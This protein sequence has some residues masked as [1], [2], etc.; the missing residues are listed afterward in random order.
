MDLASPIIHEQQCFCPAPHSTWACDPDNTDPFKC[1]SGG[2]QCVCSPGDLASP[3]NLSRQPSNMDLASASNFLRQRGN[4]ASTA[5][6]PDWAT[7]KGTYSFVKSE[8]GR[9]TQTSGTKP[10]RAPYGLAGD[11]NHPGDAEMNTAC[12]WISACKGNDECMKRCPVA[13][14]IGAKEG[15][16]FPGAYAWDGN[17]RGLWQVN[18]ATAQLPGDCAYHP[19]EGEIPEPSF[20]G[21]DGQVHNCDLYDPIKEATLVIKYTSNGKD[22][23]PPG[24]CWST[25]SKKC[26][27]GAPGY[28][29]IGGPK[30][31]EEAQDSCTAAIHSITGKSVTNEYYDQIDQCDLIHVPQCRCPAP[32]STWACDPDN[33]DPFKCGSGGGQCVCSPGDLASPLNFSRQPSNMDLASPIIHEQQCFCPAPHSTWACD[34]DNT[35]PFKCG[36]GGGQCVCSP[37]DLASPLNLSRQPSNTDLA[38]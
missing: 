15:G 29:G 11:I 38:S 14:A 6:C 37:G 12:A 2:G 31:A 21:E 16:W 34:P 4:I 20:T 24:K 30:L 36:S 17:G 13:M 19:K 28:D 9:T 3:L 5:T 27:D 22:F 33:T 1:G 26:A 32:H 8:W 23:N 10:A 25:C 7:G 18:Y 35:D